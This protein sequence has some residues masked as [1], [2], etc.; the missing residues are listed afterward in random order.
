MEEGNRPYGVGLHAAKICNFGDFGDFI[1][2][3]PVSGYTLDE[4]C[5]KEKMFNLG[6]TM[7]I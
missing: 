2:G 3:N 7:R 1:L 4:V 6:C 5:K